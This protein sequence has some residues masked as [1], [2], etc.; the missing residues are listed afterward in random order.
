MI[1]GSLLFLTFLC[2]MQHHAEPVMAKANI[3]AGLAEFSLGSLLLFH[4]SK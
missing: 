3:G 1:H 4:Y 2:T